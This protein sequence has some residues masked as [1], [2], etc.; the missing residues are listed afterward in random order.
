MTD[1]FKC[2]HPEEDHDSEL[3]WSEKKR[4]PCWYDR[5]CFCG[6]FKKGPTRK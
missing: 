1:C 6:K 4:G 3:P 5:D 2:D